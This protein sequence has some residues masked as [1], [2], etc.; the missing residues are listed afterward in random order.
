MNGM[1][2][3]GA[4]HAGELQA[5]AL[6]G[7]NARG[8]AIRNFMPEQ[9][10]EFF[11]MLR[12]LLMATADGDGWP[13]ATVLTGEAGFVSSPDARSLRILA[14]P[15][16]QDPVRPLL[17]TDSAVGMLGIDFASRRRNR[18]NGIVSAADGEGLHIAVRESF[19]K[20][21]K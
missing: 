6:A 14:A 16:L 9:H 4:F 2:D 19:G 12:F 10:R 20:F 21:P 13:V 1:N 3:P 15:D 5:Q 18:A 8:N 11:A 17:R 7:V